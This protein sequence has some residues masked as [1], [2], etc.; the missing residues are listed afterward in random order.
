MN[1]EIKAKWLTALRGGKYKQGSGFL[2][3]SQDGVEDRFCCLGVLC[4]LAVKAGV[5]AVLN[6]NYETS[7]GRN[8]DTSTAVLPFHVQEWA[9]LS[10]KAGS[11]DGGERSLTG[12]NDGGMTFAQIADIIE[13]EF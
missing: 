8:Y 4:D 13:R 9:G 3:I 1:K 12:D 11:Y 10:S 6:E 5:T 2:R 7:Y